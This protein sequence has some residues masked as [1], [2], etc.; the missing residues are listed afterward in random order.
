M[1]T[2]LKFQIPPN[3]RAALERAVATGDAQTTRLQAVY[4]DTAAQDLAKA[5]LALRLRKEGRVWVQTLKGRGDGLLN[6]LEHEVKLP[7]QGGVPVLDLQRHAGTAAGD[8]LAAA[9]PAAAALQTLYRTD[10]SRLHRQL[11]FEGAVVEVAYDRGWLIA[12][13][14]AGDGA[15]K[16][17]VN[18]IEF[19]LLSGPP[20]KLAALALRW[21]GKHALW[22]D[23]RTKSERGMRLALG[24]KSGPAVTVHVP[25]RQAADAALPAGHAALQAALAQAVGNAGEIAE[26]L[27]GPEH[28]QALR[29]ALRR[30]PEALRRMAEGENGSSDG[31]PADLAED[32][33]AIARELAGPPGAMAAPYV[34]MGLPFQTLMLRTLGL[35]LKPA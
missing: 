12:D 2:E 19:E 1:E 11:R 18:E 17:A 14:A 23:S 24:L 6:R 9:L 28:L 29:A 20:A 15:R 4:A 25:P 33:E 3:C 22:W 10:I 8:R 7:A 16:L 13:D 34:L 21:A 35:L 26:G 32:C 5:G 30:M 27:G 31:K